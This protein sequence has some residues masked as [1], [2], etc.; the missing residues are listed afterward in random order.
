MSRRLLR[1]LSAL[2]VFQFNI[3]ASFAENSDPPPPTEIFIKGALVEYRLFDSPISATIQTSEALDKNVTSTFEEAIENVPGFTWV[4]GTSRPRFFQIRGIGEFE[5]YTG[6]PNPSVGTIIDDIDFSGLGVVSSLFDA[7][8]IEVLR[9]PQGTRFGSSALAGVLNI[10]S[11]EPSIEPSARAVASVGND[12]LVEGGIAVG[13]A[14]PGTNDRVL[15]RL[16]AHHLSEDGFRNNE[17]LHRDDTNERDEFT[18]RIKARIIPDRDFII[19]LTGLAVNNDNGYDAFTIFNGFDTQSDKPGQDAIETHAGALKFTWNLSDS[20]ALINTATY[21]RSNQDYSYDGDW[22]NNAFWHPYEPYDY[23]SATDRTRRTFADELRLSSKDPFDSNSAKWSG[24]IYTQHLNEDTA[25][26]NLSDGI[27]YDKLDSSYR[28]VKS[29]AFGYADIPIIEGT[30]LTGGMSVEHL[31]ARYADSTNISLYPDDVMLGGTLGISHAISD[32][33]ELF[34]SLSRGFKGGGANPGINVPENSRVYSPEYL[35]SFEAGSRVSLLNDRLKGSASI[36]HALRRDEQLKFAFQSDPSDPLTFTYITES[37]A[38]GHATGLELESSLRVLHDLSFFGNAT[39]LDTELTSVPS[40]SE[41]LL[42]RDNSI[43]PH[44]RY[45]LGVEYLI[46]QGFFIRPEINGTAAYYFDDSHNQRSDPYHLLNLSI[47]YRTARW[48]WSIW[49]RN[50][51]D[52][53]YAVRGFY[54]GNEPPDFPN[55]LYIQ[56]G[57][58]LTFGTTLKI[59]F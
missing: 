8:R 48:E 23:F 53:R 18:G 34:S 39:I 5:Q 43:S 29:A 31:D 26:D 19:D 15:L 4:G 44:W 1:M 50:L 2:L 52:E 57:D 16:S 32:Q 59:F 25:I 51:S 40:G 38:R 17:F 27:S 46:S 9:G 14:V 22:G 58:P 11:T 56:R 47:G 49:G 37:S 42:N 45:S 6:A 20:V 33:V 41:D 55:K 54:F 36:F 24:G 3:V 35:W 12:D 21:Q 10:V 13:G 28:A 7:E 30:R